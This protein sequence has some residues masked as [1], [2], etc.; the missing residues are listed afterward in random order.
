[1]IFQSILLRDI[2]PY[3][4]ICIYLCF[5]IAIFI[6]GYLIYKKNSSKYGLFFMISAIF[7]IVPNIIYLAIDVP[8]L[9]YNL[10]VLGLTMEI[11]SNIFF[12]VN[13]LF[14]GLNVTS[15]VFLLLAIYKIYRGYSLK[16]R[17]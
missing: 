13:L 14:M 8:F 11:I 9:S 3:L 2:M 1:M 10:S 12:L 6:F 16:E 17:E 15:L 5:D 7:S 4:P